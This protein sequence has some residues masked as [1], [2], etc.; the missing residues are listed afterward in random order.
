MCIAFP[1]LLLQLLQL[2]LLLLLQLLFGRG[3]GV[4]LLFFRNLSYVSTAKSIKS[5]VGVFG[6]VSMSSL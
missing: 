1:F 5:F 3:S 2:L 4:R 6:Q